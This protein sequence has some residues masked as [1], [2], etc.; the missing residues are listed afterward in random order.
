[1]T[2]L[3][4]ADGEEERRLLFALL[5]LFSPALVLLRPRGESL[6]ANVRRRERVG[7][8][9]AED[10]SATVAS[11]ARLVLDEEVA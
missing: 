9:P 2:S 6:V 3:V 10:E 11:G 1:V 7:R 5:S 8:R 4:Q